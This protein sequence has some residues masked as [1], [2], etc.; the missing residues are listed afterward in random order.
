LLKSIKQKR[1]KFI[2]EIPVFIPGRIGLKLTRYMGLKELK[3]ADRIIFLK[4]FVSELMISL[5]EQDPRKKIEIEK[6]RQKFLNQVKTSEDALEGAINIPIFEKP[7]YQRGIGEEVFLPQDSK[8]PE[9]SKEELKELAVQDSKVN[10]PSNKL[11]LDKKSKEEKVSS[12]NSAYGMKRPTHVP[13]LHNTRFFSELRNP[14]FP[15]RKAPP[16]LIYVRSSRPIRPADQ[17]PKPVANPSFY[18]SQYPAQQTNVSAPQAPLSKKVESPNYE[19]ASESSPE[20]GF[21]K[22]SPLL[23]DLSI[24]AIECRGVGKNILVKRY[25]KIR[26]TKIILTKQETDDIIY[27]FSRRARIP[28][29]GGILKAAVGDLIISAVSSEYVGSRF[30]ISKMTTYPSFGN[31]LY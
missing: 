20:S 25:N 30:I 15:K 14:I 6:I 16:Q 23:Q 31:N 22:L 26:V 24:Q 1:S 19:L 4:L 13:K 2:T 17:N 8:M 11:S 9:S 10:I 18:R 12:K 27:N 21:G 28:V 3:P 7:V 5:S 29:V